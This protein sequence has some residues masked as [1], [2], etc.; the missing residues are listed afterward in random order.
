MKFALVCAYCRH[1]EETSTAGRRCS[2]CDGP[3]VVEVDRSALT[4][5]RD[6]PAESGLPGIWRYFP[7]LPLERRD[8]IVSLHEGGTPLVTARRLGERIGV[9]NLFLKDESRNPTGSFKDRMLAVGV[10]RAVE[11]G[12]STIVVQSSG[13]VAAAAAAYAAKA[14]LR[15][16]IFVPRTV[17]EE[18]LL[19]IQLYG[20]DLF[21]IDHDSPAAVFRLMDEVAKA[22]GWYVVSTTA[23]YNPFTLEGAKTIAYELFEQTGGELPEWIV[24][25]V[26]GGGN[27]GT[28]WRA[29][30]ELNALGLVDRLPRMVGVQAEGCAPFVEAVRLGRSAKDAA[31]TRWPEIRTVC[32]PIADD[33]V[34]DAQV[35]LPAVRKS[36]GSA[37]AVSDVETLEAEAMLAQME[38]VFVEPS[39]A[40]TIAAL[41]R[42]VTEGIVGQQSSVCCIL[43]GTGFKDI[44]SARNIVSLPG[45]I[46]PTVEAVSS[47]AEA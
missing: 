16:K 20:G 21:R 46:A 22:L 27:L 19:Q 33:V 4:N 17:P 43:T 34:F 1:R 12:K 24:V 7:L 41:R 2:E 38:G 3:F 35:A 26:G 37:V 9:S 14:G 6:V 5:T 15:A 11:L 42:L 32:G 25:P 18:K 8:A 30:R 10:S 47:R 44:G 13:N 45:L 39:S 28:I 40:T 31:T 29:F 23:L 36:G